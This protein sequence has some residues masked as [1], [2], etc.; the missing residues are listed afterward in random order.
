MEKL[1]CPLSSTAVGVSGVVAP[2]TTSWL[3]VAIEEYKSIRTESLDSMKTQNT[4]LSYGVTIIA[5]ILT[6]GIGMID[7]DNM[8]LLDAAIFLLFIPVIVFC[9]VMIWAGEVARMYRAGCFLVKRENSI[10]KYI[11]ELNFPDNLDQRVL[12][13][14]QRPL[15]WENWL[16]QETCDNAPPHKRLY[17]QHYSVLSVFLFLVVLSIMIGNFK[18]LGRT[19]KLY[20]M[21]IDIGEAFALIYLAYLALYL[22]RHFHPPIASWMDQIGS[23][24]RRLT[25]NEGISRADGSNYP[26]LGL[27]LAGASQR[28]P[29]AVDRPQAGR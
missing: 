16:L 1:T 19:D 27:S 15:F 24:S 6:V 12:F 11:S 14:D 26:I 13:R 25:N 4:I 20:V 18:I 3:S 2:K 17:I 8:L 5:A 7:K 22:L 21:M 29:F 28:L 23:K 9:V 10:N